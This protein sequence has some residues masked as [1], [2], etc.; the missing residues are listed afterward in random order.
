[1]TRKHTHKKDTF[2]V[3]MEHKMAK[4]NGNERKQRLKNTGSVS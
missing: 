4:V 3:T 2:Y 1:M